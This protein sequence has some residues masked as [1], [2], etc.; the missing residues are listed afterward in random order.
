[1]AYEPNTS[2]GYA[3]HSIPGMPWR[4]DV[5]TA[6]WSFANRDEDASNYSITWPCAEKMLG[7]NIG[8]DLENPQRVGANQTPARWDDWTISGIMTLRFEPL[9]APTR[10]GA[11]VFSSETYKCLWSYLRLF[12]AAVGEFQPNDLSAVDWATCLIKMYLSI[13]MKSL[14]AANA[15]ANGSNYYSKARHMWSALGWVDSDIYI[16][17]HLG[18]WVRRINQRIIAPLRNLKLIH[19][20]FPGANRIAALVS[21]WY[22]DSFDEKSQCQVYT[23][24]PASFWN[25]GYTAQQHTWSFTGSPMVNHFDDFLT[26]V[27]Q[28]VDFMA[29]DESML[30][31]QRYLNKI[32][33]SSAGVVGDVSIAAIELGDIPYP[34]PDALGYDNWAP[35]Y[36][37]DMLIAIH[38]ATILEDLIVGPAY[39]T[40]EG[41]WEQTCKFASP[42]ARGFAAAGYTKPIE[43]PWENANHGDYYN[44][45][46]WTVIRH[47]EAAWD[48]LICDPQV[49]GSEVITG[50][51]VYTITP[52]TAG[53]SYEEMQ[54]VSIRSAIFARFNDSNELCFLPSDFEYMKVHKHFFYA[55]VCFIIRDRVPAENNP[56]HIIDM[57]TNNTEVLHVCDYKALSS[58]KTQYLKNYWG[59]P[60]ILGSAPGTFSTSNIAGHDTTSLRNTPATEIAEY[61]EDRDE[62]APGSSFYK[63]ARD[64]EKRNKKRRPKPKKGAPAK[65]DAPDSSNSNG[66]SN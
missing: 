24:M 1:M 12:D 62:N 9:L 39:Q 40:S 35:E 31:V 63:N 56:G 21:K 34:L 28:F 61:K 37:R 22:R 17:E 15:V 6:M 29:Y 23:F 52:S 44:A 20:A 55:P 8:K 27:I 54:S 53:T 30:Q 10:E 59:Y 7:Q 2:S 4:D 47:R 58:M 41:E 42:S 13:I 19:N 16:A 46:T 49:L 57:L 25:I 32:V 48:D 64:A 3:N 14:A 26:K 38:N 33:D 51:T 43:L 50:G 60:F 45:T 18:Q 66:E 65:A 5:P 11:E 36:N